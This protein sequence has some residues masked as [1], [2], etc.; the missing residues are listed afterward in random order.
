M[1]LNYYLNR[2]INNKLKLGVIILIFIYPIIDII[3]VLLDISHGA[4]VLS[5][6]V[7]TFLSSTIFNTTQLLLIWYLPLYLV[8]IV[9]DDCIE[10][11]KT[12]YKNILI[13][14]WGK[15]SYFKTNILK[16][17]VFSFCIIFLSLM[18][19]LVLTQIIFSGGSYVCYDSDTI[20]KIDN[21]RDSLKYPL[22]TNIIYIILTSVVSGVVGMGATAISMTVHNRLIV[23]PIIYIM[24]YI[25]TALEKSVFLALQPF[26]EYSVSDSTFSILLVFTINLSAVVAAYLREVKYEDI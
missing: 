18:L 6:G 5:P 14:K 21:L 20:Q 17:F 16:G 11:Y 24:W 8:V 1:K 22:I 19:N 7:S 12:G 3:M 9:A 23:Y 13:S 4:A 2:I 25:P 10:D 15:K 26:T